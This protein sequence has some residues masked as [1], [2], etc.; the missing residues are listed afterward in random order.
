MLKL[1]FPNIFIVEDFRPSV[2]QD[3]QE[4]ALSVRRPMRQMRRRASSREGLM[5]LVWL[6]RDR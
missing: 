5:F 1:M 2:Q 4:G 6:G 3:T